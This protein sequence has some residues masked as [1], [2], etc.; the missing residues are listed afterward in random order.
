MIAFIKEIV[1]SFTSLADRKKITLKLNHDEDEIIAYLDKDKIDKIINN[2]LSNA[3][4]FTPEG[5]KN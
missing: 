2:I 4:K 3:F 5:W 1:L